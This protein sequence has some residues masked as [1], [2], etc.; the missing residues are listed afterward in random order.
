MGHSYL[1]SERKRALV[2][3]NRLEKMEQEYR[4]WLIFLHLLFNDA[5]SIESV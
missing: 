3:C 5:V 1:Q 4:T 2:M